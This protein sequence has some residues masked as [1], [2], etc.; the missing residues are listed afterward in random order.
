MQPEALKDQPLHTQIHYLNGYLAALGLL[1]SYS[2]VGVD[3]TL[4]AFSLSEGD[5]SQCIQHNAYE[6]FGVYPNDW[7]I[8]FTKIDDWEIRLKNEL[9]ASIQRRIPVEAGAAD[10]SAYQENALVKALHANIKHVNEYFISLLKTAL[11]TEA[12]DVYVLSVDTKGATYRIV[13]ID[14]VFHIAPDTILVLQING[15]D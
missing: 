8:A 9:N 6:L 13:G 7:D 11:I 5:M 3:A 12:T 2:I 10:A 14:L 15:L 4:H 1:N